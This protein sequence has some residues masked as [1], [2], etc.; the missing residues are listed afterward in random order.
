MRRQRSRTEEY[1]RKYGVRYRHIEK[2]RVGRLDAMTEEARLLLIG[3]AKKQRPSLAAVKR[4][5]KRLAKANAADKGRRARLHAM[6][7]EIELRV[8][9][10]FEQ[11]PEV[12]VRF[13]VS[14][15]AWREKTKREVRRVDTSPALA[16]EPVNSEVHLRKR[17]QRS[18]GW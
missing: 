8:E 11:L 5:Y 10:H 2:L 4:N 15:A 7:R 1:A 13:A 18:T 17:P 9:K 12:Y 3:M 14:E 16:P 6:W